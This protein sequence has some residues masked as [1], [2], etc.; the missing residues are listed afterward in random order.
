MTMYV[1]L[2][3][4]VYN[5]QN[6]YQLQ[7]MCVRYRCVRCTYVRTRQGK[8]RGGMSLKTQCEGPNWPKPRSRGLGGRN[9]TQVPWRQCIRVVP[10]KQVRSI[11]ELS[12]KLFAQSLWRMTL[13]P[14]SMNKVLLSPQNQSRCHQAY[15]NN[16]LDFKWVFYIRKKQI[17]F[18]FLGVPGPVQTP[19]EKLTQSLNQDMFCRITKY[20]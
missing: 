10:T 17:M 5:S 14:I 11:L 3:I 12:T 19:S 2:Y 9:S 6:Q 7:K 20:N 4:Y 18:Q 8:V 13:P 15:P 1:L 16:I